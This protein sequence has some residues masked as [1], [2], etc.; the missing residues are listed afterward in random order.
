MMTL[1]EILTIAFV[2][3]S[4]LLM[5]PVY[6]A[7]QTIDAKLS[8]RSL[9]PAQL[10]QRVGVVPDLGHVADPVAVELHDVDVVGRDLVAR[11]RVPMSILFGAL[12]TAGLFLS[13]QEGT[14][15]IPPYTILV[16]SLA[17]RIPQ[18]LAA[19]AYRGG[20]Q[21]LASY[22]TRPGSA[23]RIV[24]RPKTA[25]A[26][27]LEFAL[28]RYDRSDSL[29]RIPEAEAVIRVERGTAVTVKGVPRMSSNSARTSGESL[30][31]SGFIASRAKQ[32]NPCGHS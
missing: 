7:A 19:D 22:E 31:Q 8:R 21:P 24:A 6:A 1:P 15:E 17:E 4:A 3:V 10:L 32:A 11:G 13:L 25:P 5:L 20:S 9:C 26:P 2:L 18:V 12:A 23:V 27:G 14:P 16:Q 30:P 29:E 28:Y